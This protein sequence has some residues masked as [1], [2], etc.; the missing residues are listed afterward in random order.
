MTNKLVFQLGEWT[1]DPKR[2]VLKRGN[3]QH[4]IEPMMVLALTYFIQHKETTLT[5]EELM[6]MVWQGRHVSDNTVNKLIAKL[7]TV[8][9]DSIQQPQYIET[10][11][12][13]GYRL[14]CSVTIKENKKNT[15]YRCLLFNRHTLLVIFLISFILCLYYLYSP[16]KRTGEV[17]TL[18]ISDGQLIS[19]KYSSDGE[20]LA[21][22]SKKSGD[23]HYLLNVRELASSLL[24]QI[25][26][27]G[28][29]YRLPTWLPN[30]RVLYYLRLHGGECI[31][32]RMRIPLITSPQQ[33]EQSYLC[34]V[35]SISD[36]VVDQKNIYIAEFTKQ[37]GSHIAIVN[38]ETQLRKELVGTSLGSKVLYLT[39]NEKSSQL[40]FIELLSNGENHLKIVDLISGDIKLSHALSMDVLGL[41]W[42]GSDELIITANHQLMSFSLTTNELKKEY[43]ALSHIHSPTFNAVTNKV[44]VVTTRQQDLI[45]EVSLTK[46]FANKVIIDELSFAQG[47]K[48]GHQ[49][50]HFVYLSNQ[51]GSYQLWYSSESDD[52]RQLTD[53]ENGL[54]N[55]EYEWSEDDTKILLHYRNNL[56]VVH[57]NDGQIQHLIEFKEPVLSINWFNN[58][59]FL[60]ATE[61]G[62]WQYSFENNNKKLILPDIKINRMMKK[63]NKL[64]YS[65]SAGE[66]LFYLNLLD[67]EV[68][69]VFSQLSPYDNSWV[70]LQ[71]KLYYLNND[72]SHHYHINQLD[73]LTQ[74]TKSL[75]Q[76]ETEQ[77]AQF[78]VKPDNKVL[79][80]T[81]GAR[82]TNLI[83]LSLDDST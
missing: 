18:P 67:H 70:I 50:D 22:I 4:V 23:K 77:V 78:T 68:V 14:I 6:K 7:R 36:F 55:V 16:S 58:K 28:N 82:K 65:V 51:N 80:T 21:Y 11:A 30:E 56:A 61:Q 40:A 9:G 53:I 47:A 24:L 25:K 31:I 33:T 3:V 13:Q 34:N 12:K 49:E 81:R 48:Y 26:V 71:D 66:Q 63:A 37:N 10:I 60:I 20:L 1:F 75:F 43:Q 27:S 45:E 41:D 54:I 72:Q 32:E 42:R 57:L 19:P 17:E 46:V 8:L 83:T 35:N 79:I 74:Q 64:F 29:D 59:E 62:V 38:Q 5:R 76:F 73:L 15:S 52:L 69:N 39:L 44:A 2:N